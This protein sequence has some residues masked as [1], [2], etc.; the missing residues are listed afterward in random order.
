[1]QL[2]V[3][4]NA[5]T[6]ESV[7][8]KLA[9]DREASLPIKI[10]VAGNPATPVSTLAELAGA[11]DGSE[12][13]QLA[14]A[15]N[16]SAPAQT[17]SSLAD[18]K[19]LKSAKHQPFGM[20]L[21]ANPATPT[22]TRAK[23]FQVDAFRDTV[24]TTSP[25]ESASQRTAHLLGSYVP[26][27]IFTLLEND[28]DPMVRRAVAMSPRVSAEILARL[29]R[30]KNQ[31]VA[32]V[33]QARSASDSSKLRELA[34]SS[35]PLVLE[36]LV[37]NPNVPADLRNRAALATIATA[38]ADTLE[39]VAKDPSAPADVLHAIATHSTRSSA[40]QMPRV[41][42][43]VLLNP[44]IGS[45]TL[46]FLA[47]DQNA[48]VRVMAGK[49]PGLPLGT[50]VRL[51]ADSDAAV[52]E[53]VA[54]NP[55]TPADLLLRLSTD[56]TPAVVEAVATHQN[57][58]ATVLKRAA[59]DQLERRRT[60]RP[61]SPYSRDL[62]EFHLGPL[63]AVASNPNTP[64]DTL[65]TVADSVDRALATLS[66]YSRDETVVG[67]EVSVWVGMASN[68]SA[69]AGVLDSI[70]RTVHK[71][72]W[73][74]TDPD[75]GKRDLEKVRES[76]LRAIVRNPSASTETLEFLSSG[77]W[78]ARR[79]TT[80]R[81]RSD[82][83]PW[84]I[85]WTI[86][87]PSA[88]A[89]AKQDMASFV[90][91]EISRRKWS[92]AAGTAN[93]LTFASSLDAPPEL[94]DELSNDP[95]IAVRRAVAANSST[96]PRVFER[97]A[98][99]PSVEVRL[100]AAAATHPD[101]ASSRYER[102]GHTRDSRESEYGLAF[103]RLAADV[104]PQVRVAVGANASAFWDAL[105]EPAR[106]RMVFDADPHVRES[107]SAAI[108]AKE[109]S[110]VEDFD[111][112]VDAL[113]HLINTGD[114]DTWRSLAAR[115]GK[116]P[117]EVLHRLLDTGDADTA[118]LVAEHYRAVAPL[119]TTLARSKVPAVVNAVASRDYFGPEDKALQDEVA[120]VLL[121]NPLT[122]SSF[123]E[124]VANRAHDEETL[125]MAV[126]HA[127]FPGWK[128]LNYAAG[129]DQ[130]RLRAAASTGKAEVFTALAANPATPVELLERIA[131]SG[132]AEAR[133]AL[134][135]NETTPPELLV[136]LI[137]AGK[138]EQ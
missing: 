84:T 80:P 81:E 32:W 8:A 70:A 104:E 59:S 50:L 125:H 62:P 10:A 107:V 23:L 19:D 99:D 47:S 25:L 93:R 130:R 97:L 31:D 134:L 27:E 92:D 103:E 96:S 48:H 88:T 42:Q 24:L 69:P 7:L 13:V 110:F 122:P 11:R 60:L 18:A 55:A 137:Q 105:P 65:L 78:V 138:R 30:D 98:E 36:A 57:A 132:G 49:H 115:R 124:T 87:D 1:V 33:V 131:S 100:A 85:T 29:A 75:L 26:A 51:A 53:S 135:V 91:A 111:L 6:P 113:L 82:A 45:E 34:R 102:G 67:K 106:S 119:L 73:T 108:S 5:A 28:P 68:R 46:T 22:P 66:S 12:E 43:A 40:W 120:K 14:I 76:T 101:R 3:A 116:L 52:R 126:K 121:R 44:A 71:E 15:S 4:R 16:H 35:D 129:T 37:W 64:V 133:Q 86:W 127:N 2:A 9:S 123:L 74:K 39:M 117:T 112:S 58:S 61:K 17:L 128:L 56:E 89:A 63:V 136:R 95:D 90:R 79:T 72:V 109:H 114:R 83:G 77:E 94:L 118:A 54:K 20:A 38:K 21:A 41:K